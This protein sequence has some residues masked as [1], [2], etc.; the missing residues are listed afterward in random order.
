MAILTSKT[1]NLILELGNVTGNLG[2]SLTID[3]RLDGK[4]IEYKLDPIDIWQA[5]RNKIDEYRESE[6]EYKISNMENEGN[7]NTV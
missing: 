4:K 1:S 3:V 5:V 6:D 2:G 7:P